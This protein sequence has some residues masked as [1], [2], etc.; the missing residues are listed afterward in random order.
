M[1]QARWHVAQQVRSGA[2]LGWHTSR[3]QEVQG[4]T[5]WITYRGMVGYKTKPVG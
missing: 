2:V 5:R 1:P 3:E 4:S